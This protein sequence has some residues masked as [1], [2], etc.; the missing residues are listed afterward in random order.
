MKDFPGSTK[1]PEASIEMKPIK[2]FSAIVMVLVLAACAQTTA[3]KTTSPRQEETRQTPPA[4]SKASSESSESGQQESQVVRQAHHPEPGRR[5]K[6]KSD[7]TTPAEA[8]SDP[9]TEPRSEAPAEFESQKSSTAQA[10]EEDSAEAKL[11]QA[12]ENLHISQET[13]KR[14]ATELE[15]LKESGSGSEEAVRD[16][17]TY[18]ESVAA[19]T[20]ENRKIVDQLE[21]VY[22]KKTSGKTGSNELDKMADPDIPEEQ[23]L[24]EVAALDSQL[25]A[26]LAKFD[27]ML[28]EEM[29]EIRAGSS[30]KLQDLAAEAAEAAKRLREKGLDVN[31]SG[32][33]PSGESQGNREKDSTKSRQSTETASRDSSDKGS[34]STDQRRREYENDD[35]VARQLREAAENETDPELKEKLWKEYEEYKKSK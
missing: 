16:Y 12:R 14:I 34:S 33:K 27:G 13:E 11:A 32:S 24:D 21:A 26:S 28:L 20:A 19:M 22:A 30:E 23:A 31:T 3:T 4:E 8:A 17:E 1:I 2:P 7:E 35:I 18:L 5:A 10:S 15:Q 29:D 25:N 6:S 9:K